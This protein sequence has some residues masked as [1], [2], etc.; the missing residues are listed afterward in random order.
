MDDIYKLLYEGFDVGQKVNQ[1]IKETLEVKQKASRKLSWFSIQI[2]SPL[3]K[4][5]LSHL[6]AY[7][8]RAKKTLSQK[9][10]INPKPTK[11]F[12]KAIRDEDETDEGSFVR[13]GS[14]SEK[15]LRPV[16]TAKAKANK[17]LVNKN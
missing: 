1:E 9:H 11:K 16:R 10:I 4:A 2:L 17:H 14:G 8:D 6:E 12:M 3:Q 7:L 5:D 15:D 13:D